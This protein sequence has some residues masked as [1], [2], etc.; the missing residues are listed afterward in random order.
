MMPLIEEV[1]NSMACSSRSDIPSAVTIRVRQRTFVTPEL[2]SVEELPPI[3]YLH[4]EFP[5]ECWNFPNVATTVTHFLEHFFIEKLPKDTR[6][7]HVFWDSEDDI[8]KV[9]T[10]IPEP[11][12]SLEMPIYEAETAF[13]ETFP[14]YQCDFYVIYRFGKP[15][16]DVRPQGARLVL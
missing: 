10:V 11:D 1:N 4:V 3:S 12:F 5:T 15:L 9:W 13:M 6:I 2:H 8:L 16:E 14:S 7:E